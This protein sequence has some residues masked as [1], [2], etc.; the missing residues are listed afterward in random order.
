MSDSLQTR[1][2]GGV[3]MT[4]TGAAITLVLV[5]A[6]ALA[7][8]TRA[9]AQTLYGP[10]PYA[11][12]ADSPL[13]DPDSF[14][15]YHL[16]TFEDDLFNTPGV[17]ASTGYMVGPCAICD[18]ADS[19]DGVIDGNG[20][21]RDWWAPGP[22]G[23]TFT[24]DAAVLGHLPTHVGLVWTDGYSNIH[25][26]AFDADGHSL[27]TRDGSHSGTG[28]DCAGSA[29]E[30]RFYGVADPAGIKSVFIQCGMGVGGG[31]EVDHLQY[32]YKVAAAAVG[33]EGSGTA[34]AWFRCC[35]PNPSCGRADLAY[36]LARPGHVDVDVYDMAGRLVS[37][38]LA[39][40]QAAGE[41]QVTWS[42]RTVAS[43][44]YLV[45]LVVDGELATTAKLLVLR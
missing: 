27:G 26:E 28:W 14:A 8:P 21:G 35:G 5:A 33:D 43:G 39:E 37:R 31:I 25:F 7:L 15:W 1:W 44:N 24:F 41:H 18:S 42:D 10:L 4:V 29:N 22:S 3:V 45:R 6:L 32:G 13:G 30:D 34:R 38:V 36:A 12:P 16:E 23:V 40:H 9:P 11:S 2:R 20:C 17:S 19:D